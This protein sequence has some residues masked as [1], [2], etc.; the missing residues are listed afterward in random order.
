[1][2]E[3][4]TPAEPRDVTPSFAR[5]FP[6]TPELDALVTAFVRGDYRH[7]RD[8]APKLAER[9]EDA[10]V[11]DAARLLRTRTEA[12]PLAKAVLLGTGLLLALLAVW[13]ALHDGPPHP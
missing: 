13:W 12:D 10:R 8:E 4:E 5:D 9:A 6:R 11:R 1:M 3:P 2:S 7:V